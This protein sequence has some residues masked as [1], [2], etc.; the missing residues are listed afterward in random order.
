MIMTSPDFTDGRNSPVDRNDL[1]PTFEIVR[2]IPFRKVALVV[3]T[4]GSMEGVCKL[5]KI[6][7]LIIKLKGFPRKLTQS[8]KKNS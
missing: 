7:N 4:S 8:R 6:I 3:D 1:S 5:V 2:P